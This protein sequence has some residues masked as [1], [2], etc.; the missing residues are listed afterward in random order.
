MGWASGTYLAE[1][2]IEAAK[3]RISDQKSRAE[4][5]KVFLAA[6]E[7]LDWDTQDEVI[8]IDDVFDAVLREAHPGWYE[9]P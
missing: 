8:G 6:M 7:D 1:P 2:V 9:A 4:F 3:E 5:Y